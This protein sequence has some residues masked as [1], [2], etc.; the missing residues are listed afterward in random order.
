MWWGSGPDYQA[1]SEGRA[2]GDRSAS[3]PR[4]TGRN[5]CRQGRRSPRGAALVGT[6][7]YR[8]PRARR[9]APPGRGATGRPTGQPGLLLHA[10]PRR[11]LMTVA[12][13]VG[14]PDWATGRAGA[15]AFPTSMLGRDAT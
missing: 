6:A 7:A 13:V 1:Q 15:A 2:H 12:A 14:S 5:G 9:Q 4:T 11:V 8:A 10:C 3:R